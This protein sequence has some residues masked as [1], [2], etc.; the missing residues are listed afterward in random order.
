MKENVDLH[1]IVIGATV[2]VNSE[3]GSKEKGN[4]FGCSGAVKEALPPKSFLGK[5]HPER[6]PGKGIPGKA[7]QP[8]QRSAAP[9]SLSRAFHPV[10]SPHRSTARVGL[11]NWPQRVEQGPAVTSASLPGPG[12][13]QARP[14]M[15]HEARPPLSADRREVGV[16]PSCPG[17]HLPP[18]MADPFPGSDSGHLSQHVGTWTTEAAG[19]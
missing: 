16:H 11:G 15:M 4:H 3:G 13:I 6:K 8:R 1:C 14:E 12:Q 9:L 18:R 5:S 17:Q 19:P 7:V 2:E 10:N